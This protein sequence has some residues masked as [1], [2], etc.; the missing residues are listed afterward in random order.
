M[1]RLIIW[2]SLY[3]YIVRFSSLFSFF[4]FG[5]S[6]T[7]YTLELDNISFNEI[8]VGDIPLKTL[9]LSSFPS[10]PPF[11]EIQKVLSARRS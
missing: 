4:I 5:T 10:S 2:M 6:I 3:S 1:E 9:S 7:V 8:F 11:R